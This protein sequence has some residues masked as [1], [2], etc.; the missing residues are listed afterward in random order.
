MGCIREDNYSNLGQGNEKC[1]WG[2]ALSSL[3]KP[4]KFR[5]KS[6]NKKDNAISVRGHANP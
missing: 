1:N 4:R 2:S 5:D 6:K 3:T